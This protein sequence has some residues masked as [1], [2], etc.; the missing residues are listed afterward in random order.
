MMENPTD[1]S[2]SD[3]KKII[4]DCTEPHAKKILEHFTRN[5]TLEILQLVQ[6]PS[7]VCE[8]CARTSYSKTEMYKRLSDLLDCGLLFAMK[9]DNTGGEEYGSWTYVKSFH[10]ISVKT[11]QMNMRS[12]PQD[13]A[14]TTI[15]ILPKRNTYAEI[16]QT[17][18]GYPA[19]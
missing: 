9:K 17:V 10:A 4:L 15:E 19:Q 16:L 14:A 12:D 8:I 2:N 1:D 5:G 13:T 11:G 18:N 3:Y 7:T 6:N